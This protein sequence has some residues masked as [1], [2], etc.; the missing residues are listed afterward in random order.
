[1]KARNEKRGAEIQ[2]LSY[3]PAEPYQL[4]LEIFRVSE[5][6]E[7]VGMEP[8]RSTHRYA[9]HMLLCVTRGESTHMVDFRPVHCKPGSLLLV[10]AEQAH[11]FGFQEDWDGW[12]VLFR[13][14]FIESSPAVPDLRIAVGLERLDEHLSLDDDERR[15]VTEATARMR[16]DT[17]LDAPP[18]DVHALLRY[19]L[20][21]LLLRLG[22]LHGEREDRSGAGPRTLRRFKEFRQL[23]EA[24]F[25]GWHQVADYAGELGCSEKSLTRATMEVAGM[26]AKAFIASRI[27][28]E[29]KRLLAHTALSVT[30]IGES[31][32]FDEATNFVKFFK[33]GAGCTPAEFR[34]RQAAT[35]R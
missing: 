31:L 30:S 34:R 21:A 1:M 5:L 29:A 35:S 8:L 25:A 20:Y 23:V 6:R 4:D 16:E 2:R 12:M 13:P 9:F 19:Q 22:I 7:R 32:G 18:A 15:V 3:R 11:N 26:N 14:E 17:K 33:R 24:N 27:T 28:L 10:H